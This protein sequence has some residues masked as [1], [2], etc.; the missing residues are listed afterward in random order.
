MYGSKSGF[1]R[2]PSDIS[3]W[4]SR[5][6]RRPAARYQLGL[7]SLPLDSIPMF[8]F[9]NKRGEGSSEGQPSPSH[10]SIEGQA[11]Q[12]TA[13]VRGM[14]DAV[15]LEERGHREWAPQQS[16]QHAWNGS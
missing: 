9:A 5:F 7:L 6:H 8:F 16:C 11:H 2:R 4:R 10:R 15:A 3:S 13:E 1:R 14:P 12:G